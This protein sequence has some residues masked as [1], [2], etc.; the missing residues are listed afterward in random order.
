MQKRYIKNLDMELSP[1]GFGIMRLPMSD[2]NF[3][4]E[5]YDL[6]SA[7]KDSGINYF[8]TAYPYLGGRSEEL[9]RDVLVAK[10]PRDT[11]YIADKLPVWECQNYDDMERIFKIQLERLGVSY[12]DFYLLHGLHYSRWLDI[13]NKGVLK[14]LEEKQ[15]R[16]LILKIGFSMHDTGKT[17]KLILDKYNWDFVQLQINYYDWI[18]N[19]AKE[20]YD[21]LALNDIPCIVMEPVGGGR[22][23]K[24]PNKAER[25]LKAA[26]PEASISS[27][28]VR[29]VASLPNI[30]VTLS[31]MSNKE[32]LRDNLLSFNPIIPMTDQE[33][34]IINKVV[35]IIRSNNTI[36]CTTCRYCVEECPKK[37]D[38]P[39]IFQ[40]YNDWKVFSNTAR[41][42]IDYFAFIPDGHRADA[43]LACGKCV[44]KCPQCINI[45]ENLRMI[46][47]IAIDVSLG[48]HHK[49][50][51]C[52][53]KLLNSLSIRGALGFLK[54]IS[55][56]IQKSRP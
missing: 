20:N 10:Y 54:K 42:D 44:R 29:Y 12:I 41:F 40:R 15:K 43:C 5:V 1:L 16:G 55:R 51:N 21:Y 50:L 34:A 53:T 33:L 48:K 37:I 8:D 38:I 18:M 39:Q 49:K 30:A 26:N 56:K 11:F 22:L 46:H 9:V 47:Y 35:S 31:G 4:T 2:N 13:Y 32:Q 7:A 23:S 36:P 6:I 28:A 19:R 45:P 24:L 25:M 3:P 27:W 14:F 17:L 52:L